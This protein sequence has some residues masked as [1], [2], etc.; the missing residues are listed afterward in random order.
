MSK[1]VR[2]E[3]TQFFHIARLPWTCAVASSSARV[4]NLAQVDGCLAAFPGLQASSWNRNRT[5]F[6]THNSVCRIVQDCAVFKHIFRWRACFFSD[7]SMFIDEK[8][9]NVPD[10]SWHTLCRSAAQQGEICRD[11]Q[12]ADRIR[13]STLLPVLRLPLWSVLQT[14]AHNLYVSMVPFLDK[15]GYDLRIQNFKTKKENIS[16]NATLYNWV[17]P[18]KQGVLCRMSASASPHACCRAVVGEAGSSGSIMDNCNS[19]FIQFHLAIAALTLPW[20]P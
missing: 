12:H 10:I 1:A 5:N 15:N 18:P 16:T 14:T 19:S 8:T 11:H 4:L 7:P 2:F 6:L 17:R 13:P 3:L 20:K 9:L